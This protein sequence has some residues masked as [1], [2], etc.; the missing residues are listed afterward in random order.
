MNPIGTCQAN[1]S[2]E[3][4]KKKGR[5]G[6][7]N[8]GPVY[9]QKDQAPDPR[10][11]QRQ[12]R[13]QREKSQ[14]N[15]NK[16]TKQGNSKTQR[17]IDRRAE[18]QI[19]RRTEG[20]TKGGESVYHRLNARKGGEPRRGSQEGGR[21]QTN[22]PIQTIPRKGGG[23]DSPEPVYGQKSRVPTNPRKE[24]GPV[25]GAG[26]SKTAKK[27]PSTSKAALAAG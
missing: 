10:A 17:Q 14:E 11:Q 26:E 6:A 13:E 23:T 15:R 19:K 16:T 24:K 12:T 25:Q 9:G 21:E 4:E 27:A 1:H 18:H 8:P 20:G 3:R 5:D 7:G 22:Q 2:N